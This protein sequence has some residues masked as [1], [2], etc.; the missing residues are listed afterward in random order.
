MTP[1]N[2]CTK[3]NEI[4]KRREQNPGCSVGQEWVG[5]FGLADAN[6]FYG[7]NE[8]QGCTV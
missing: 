2:P 3:Q 4:H 6:T 1:K 7:M 5:S 8:Q